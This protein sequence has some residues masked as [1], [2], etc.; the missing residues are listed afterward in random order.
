[1]GSGQQPSSSLMGRWAVPRGHNIRD[2]PTPRHSGQPQWLLFL[3]LYVRQQKWATFI[4][5]K[6][7]VCFC[8][9]GPRKG[10]R[11]G[12]FLDASWLPAWKLGENSGHALL[13]TKLPCLGQLLVQVGTTT[14][15]SLRPLV[16]TFLE[17][18]TT[19][20]S[21][22]YSRHHSPSST[23]SPTN[24]LE[25]PDMAMTTFWDT[26]VPV[27]DWISC[28]GGQRPWDYGGQGLAFEPSTQRSSA[29]G[30]GALKAGC[31]N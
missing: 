1:M 10:D 28:R 5:E 26:E 22:Q 4:G 30:K 14:G 9:P 17:T 24:T 12:H 15:A 16:Q 20:G 13:S 2:S 29:L 19:P 7:K 8:Q 6:Y 27:M 31:W 21:I 23:T 11:K 18:K 3:Y 25:M